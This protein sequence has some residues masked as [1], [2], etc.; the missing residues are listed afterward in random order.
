MM[1]SFLIANLVSALLLLVAVQ[2]HGFAPFDFESEFSQDSKASEFSYEPQ[3]FPESNPEEPSLL[4]ESEFPQDLIETQNFP[5]SN[6]ELTSLFSESQLPQD[7][8]ET[9][10]FPEKTS[11]I[12]ENEFPKEFE[13][14]VEYFES[15]QVPYEINARRE[16]KSPP[17]APAPSPSETPAPSPSEAPAP[18]EEGNT[19]KYKCS[20]K[21]RKE[22]FPLLRKLCNHVCK[23]KCLLRYSVLIYSCTS[24]CAESMPGIFKSD[25][26]KAAGYVDYCYKKCI[27]KF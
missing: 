13:Y 1:K 20:L 19:C 2:V 11:Q 8:L 3:Y 16:I 18:S 15:Q 27:K 21:C 7:S 24:R 4:S 5:K 23:T 12:S 14:P 25:M 10:N 9:Q 26:K 6:D 22:K 17:P